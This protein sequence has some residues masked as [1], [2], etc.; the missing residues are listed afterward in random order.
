[1]NGRR[2]ADLKVVKMGIGFGFDHTGTHETTLYSL[3]DLATGSEYRFDSFANW[4]LGSVHRVSFE[5]KG[6]QIVNPRPVKSL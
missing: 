3:V 6:S 2:R 4:K 1:M 5:V